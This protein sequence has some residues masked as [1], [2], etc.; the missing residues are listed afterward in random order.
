M[1]CAS[2]IQLA[3]W[4]AVVL[5][6]GLR[7]TPGVQ[8]CHLGKLVNTAVYFDGVGNCESDV[9]ARPASQSA[10]GSL[11]VGR[12]RQAIH[13][14]GPPPNRRMNFLPAAEP[15][16]EANEAAADRATT[17]ARFWR[18]ITVEISGNPPRMR[19]RR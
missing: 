2:Q 5:D 10:L 14:P 6:V 7:P 9:D 4:P 17:V 16:A 8:P 11:D 19:G 18:C 15:S 1:C 3:W 13:H 12:H